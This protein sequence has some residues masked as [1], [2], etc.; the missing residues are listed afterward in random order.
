MGLSVC[1]A[2]SL[3]T[4]LKG[5]YRNVYIMSFSHKLHTIV[6]FMYGIDKRNR[7]PSVIVNSSQ[8]RKYEA[9]VTSCRPPKKHFVPSLKRGWQASWRLSPRLKNH[10]KNSSQWSLLDTGQWISVRSQ[11]GLVLYWFPDG[12]ADH[13]GEDCFSL[14]PARQ[15]ST[16]LFNTQVLGM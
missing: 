9:S 11:S 8:Y 7:D 13:C 14:S 10:R 1:V 2:L 5:N 16:D 12:E 15:T 6:R 3:V 4:L